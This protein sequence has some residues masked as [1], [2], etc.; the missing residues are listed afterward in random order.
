[1]NDDQ[2]NRERRERIA[3]ALETARADQEREEATREAARE[4]VRREADNP[5]RVSD[6]L[7]RV[8]EDAEKDP[9]FYPAVR[10]D[11]E[12]LLG[13]LIDEARDQAGNPE[14][15]AG[16]REVARQKAEAL[17]DALAYFQAEYSAADDDDDQE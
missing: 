4:A 8:L 3:R 14:L 1:M 12:G 16:W 2:E 9:A 6:L 13:E 10:D 5:H 11:F 7:E 15:D 17:N